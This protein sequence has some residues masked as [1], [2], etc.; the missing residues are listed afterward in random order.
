M[1]GRILIESLTEWSKAPILKR[2]RIFL[3]WKTMAPEISFEQHCAC[4]TS[5]SKAEVKE[6]LL[7][8]DGPL[9]IDFTEKYLDTLDVDRLRHILMAAVI[10]AQMK[11]AAS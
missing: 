11:K 9:K 2:N 7:H 8:F 1:L 6:R 3:E 10:T 4:I 5:L